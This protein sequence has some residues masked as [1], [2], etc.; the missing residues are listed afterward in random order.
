MDILRRKRSNGT[1][2]ASMPPPSAPSL[3]FTPISPVSPISLDGVSSS[4]SSGS[5]GGSSTAAI[6]KSRSHNDMTGLTTNSRTSSIDSNKS[7]F[8]HGYMPR[9]MRTLSRG[10]NASIRQSA[11]SSTTSMNTAA[12]P[13]DVTPSSSSPQQQFISQFPRKVLRKSHK[14]KSSSHELNSRRGSTS[15]DVFSR[16]SRASTT[17]SG[18]SSSNV[19]DWR[20]QPIEMHTSLDYPESLSS[21]NRLSYLVATADYI[22]IFKTRADAFAALPQLADVAAQSPESATTSKPSSM[23]PPADPVHVIP[24]HAIIS[25]FRADTMRPPYGIEIWWRM[26]YPAIAT[27]SSTIYF[28]D[29]RDRENYLDMLASMV[30]MRNQ[31]QPDASRVYYEV[32]ECIRKVFQAEEPGFT[33]TIPEIFPVVYRNAPDR[34]KSK[35]D[36]KQLRKGQIEGVSSHYLVVGVNLCFFIQIS[37]ASAVQSTALEMK[38]Q[39]CGLVTLES[40]AADWTSRDERFAMRFR[41]PFK[42]PVGLELSSRHYR[43]IILT[44]TKADKFLKPAWPTQWQIQEVFH[45]AG[46]PTPQHI[47]AGEDFGG[48]QRTLSAFYAA[49]R[50]NP[51]DWEINWRTPFAPEFR[52]LPSVKGVYTDLQLLA[53]L[54]AL[55]YNDYFKSL[56]FCDVDL[57]G[58][59]GKFDSSRKGNVAYLSR[60]GVCLTPHET[61]L[62]QKASILYQEFHALAFSS[63][64]V[65]QI[66]FTNCLPALSKDGDASSRS[67]QFVVPIMNLLAAG[68]TRCNRLLLR[69]CHLGDIDVDSLASDQPEGVIAPGQEAVSL[70]ALDVA[71]CGLADLHMKMLFQAL[72]QSA[73][74][75]QMLDV[76]QN[77]GRAPAALIQQFM[78][79]VGSLRQ[80][81]LASGITGTFEGELLP[82]EVL[83]R[84]EY[85]EVL[86]ISN[87]KLN[88]SSINALETFLQTLSARQASMQNGGYGYSLRRLVLNNC[89][90][91][92]HLAGRIFNAM[93]GLYD[94]HLH[95]SSNPL[96]DGIEDFVSALGHNWGGRFGLHL[97][98]IEFQ[99]EAKY[100]QLMGALASNPFIDYLSLVGTAPVPVT[101][102]ACSDNTIEA[103]ER[104]FEENQSVRYLD[105]SGYCGKLDDGQ[106]GKGFGRAL[107]GLA[108]NKTL[109]HLRVR[110]QRLHDSTGTFGTAVQANKA[111]LYLDCGDNG[112]NATSLLYMAKSLE[113]NTTL[114]VYPFSSE[115]LEDV[116]KHCVKDIPPPPSPTQPSNSKHKKK[117]SGPTV[118]PG[119]ERQKELLRGEIEAAASEIMSYMSRNMTKLQQ[120]T[121]CVLDLGEAYDTC[122]ERGWPSL[123]L[124]M[125][126][127]VMFTTTPMEEEEEQDMQDQSDGQSMDQLSTGPQS[128][129]HSGASGTPARQQPINSSM[130]APQITEDMPYRVQP[131]DEALNSPIDGSG[132]S[133]DLPKTPKVASETTIDTT[134]DS[135]FLEKA[136]LAEPDLSKILEK[137]TMADGTEYVIC[138]ES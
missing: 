15:S 133:W 46:L 97:N 8:F 72:S 61:S 124:R 109:T 45:V 43:R 18:S 87:F 29:G 100:I 131:D 1:Q 89:G 26:P 119:L 38:Y 110:N 64:K 50:C 35:A 122:G 101:D 2:Q 3:T 7:G 132:L 104:F 65:R 74:T 114:L 48:F 41:D 10:S 70:E 113:T 4:T 9:A 136:F 47:V 42:S 75:L 91:T 121:G 58:L 12:T 56:S 106:L 33:N 25:V 92:G 118:D 117:L 98:M 21:K 28:K 116:L 24:L 63:G 11:A 76:S 34:I 22:I 23:L 81:N 73:W 94:I 6:S 130:V 44:L 32:E 82:L 14:R 39:T 138:T 62:V 120:D 78:E 17:M 137:F 126:E 99:N 135:S 16:M 134:L 79:S 36:D 57:S 83:D 30:K 96:E 5:K 49:Y 125:P 40:F 67:V 66:D 128:S 37:R 77:F 54:R 53:V 68:L 55:R 102:D 90:I 129:S 88:E 86:D 60:N 112:F 20:I 93:A 69:G 84:L 13:P 95:L 107:R 71:S 127:G 105:I 27:C 31:D 108:N 123:Q 52:V 19:I 111:L 51:V 115:D 103:L 59:L 80:L 85:L